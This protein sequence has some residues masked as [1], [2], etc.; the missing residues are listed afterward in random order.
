[1][2]IKSYLV[3][4]EFSLIDSKKA[5]LIYGENAGLKV[6]I[7]NYLK[8]KYANLGPISLFQDELISNKKLLVKEVSNQSL[9]DTGK[10][11]IINEATDKILEILE[12]VLS[13]ELK[14]IKIILLSLELEK[15]SKLRSLFEK[16]NALA[17]IACYQDNELN[18][19]KYIIAKLKGYKNLTTESINLIIKNGNND[20]SII[21]NEINK[22]ETFF[23]EKEIKHEQLEELLNYKETDNFNDLRD[24]SLNGNKSKLNELISTTNFINTSTMYYIA[25][26]NQRL[27]KL[28]ET[29]KINISKK[30]IVK[31]TEM[32]K[33]KIFWKEK[34]TFLSQAKKW[35]LNK[36][37]KTLEDLKDLEILIKTNSTIRPEILIK[38]FLVRVCRDI[39]NGA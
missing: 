3:Q 9:F 28:K 32:L 35:K 15:K 37:D 21:K 39:T 38:N 6:D 19:R 8:K 29:L 20:R 30:N 25:S 1:M 31:A 34:E 4:E 23:L 2:I 26:L 22:I 7:K 11:L 33:P 16:D 5:T 27:N 10:L 17:C 24:A 12:E 36:I 18:L 13:S 14:D